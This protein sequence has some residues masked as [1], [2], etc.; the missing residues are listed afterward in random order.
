MQPGLVHLWLR[1]LAW[2]P[3]SRAFSWASLSYFL[4][5]GYLWQPQ[6][7]TQLH[8]PYFALPP[9]LLTT[10]FFLPVATVAT[11]TRALAGHF[12]RSDPTQCC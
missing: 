11:G 9:L 10:L 5:H 8:K 6:L 2:L 1:E 4:G 3:S 7:D 12:R